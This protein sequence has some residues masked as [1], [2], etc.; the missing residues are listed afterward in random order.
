[1]VFKNE[2]TKALIIIGAVLTTAN[3]IIRKFDHPH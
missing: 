3:A 1:M 2:I